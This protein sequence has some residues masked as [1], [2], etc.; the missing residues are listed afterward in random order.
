MDLVHNPT[1][2]HQLSLYTFNGKYMCWVIPEAG[3]GRTRGLVRWTPLLVALA[4]HRGA[5]QDT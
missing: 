3:A 5:R 4:S 1:R 2:P